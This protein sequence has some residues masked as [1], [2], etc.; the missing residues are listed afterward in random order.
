MA[1]KASRRAR[2][3][4]EQPLEELLP[5]APEE[6]FSNY[7]DYAVIVPNYQELVAAQGEEQAR[8]NLDYIFYFLS[9]SAELLDE[10][11]F[12]DLNWRLDAHDYLVYELYT[13][14]QTPEGQR[15]EAL[16]P[17]LDDEHVRHIVHDGLRRYLTPAMRRDVERRARTLARRQAGS[18]LAAEAQTVAIALEGR[19]VE[20]LT[21]GLLVESLRSTLLQAVANLPE[22]LDREW[23]ERESTLD[24]WL[25][26]L[27][28]A[29]AEHP[30]EEAVQRLREAGPAALPFA[31]YIYYTAE[32]EGR[33]DDYAFRTALD[34]AAG[35]PAGQS[36]WLLAGAIVDCPILS[37]WVAEQLA[38]SM[39]GLA[40]AYCGYLLTDPL[41][42]NARLAAAGLE[43]V[44]AARCPA[45]FN[46]A[47]AGLSYRVADAAQTEAVQTAA[48]E[49]L[50][51][52][53]DPA[54]I[55]ILR[56][57]LGDER[58]SRAARDGLL[59]ALRGEPGRGWEE[60]TQ[61][62]PLARP[63]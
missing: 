54:A 50:L 32:Q 63:A 16:G 40:C 29:D 26:A 35:I 47:R 15:P 13:Y 45:A 10:P 25:E 22:L 36:L 28:E 58:A 52:L 11:E 12:K 30:A 34:L 62:L 2:A 60:I 48:W 1:K 18:L 42:A 46:L 3:A 51:A 37:H 31:K 23:D 57:Y 49:A 56:S 20:P 41:P 6:R 9:H 8:E 4:R 53:G 39:P 38:T 7:A 21:V 59:E 24:R 17:Q 43:V 27:L 55:P 33:C 61:G 14:A 5:L 19:T 44:V